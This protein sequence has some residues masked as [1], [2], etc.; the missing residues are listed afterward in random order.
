MADP[1][2]MS[3]IALAGSTILGAQAQERA[4]EK[5]WEAGLIQKALNEVAATQEV[6]MGQYRAR[7]EREQA[8]TTAKRALALAAA[9]GSA[10][11][12]VNLSG[13]I[14]ARGAYNAAIAM[15]DA[16]SRAARLKYEGEMGTKMGREARRAGRDMAGATILSGVSQYMAKTKPKTGGIDWGATFN[17]SA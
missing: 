6:A 2:T 12:I 17:V 8:R 16:E 11:D 15:H 9:G 10:D 5:Q 14:E 7:G 3:T 1:A 13:D 4:G